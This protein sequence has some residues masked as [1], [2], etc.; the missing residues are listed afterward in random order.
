M[1]PVSAPTRESRDTPRILIVDDQPSNIQVL[2]EALGEGYEI[3]FATT[4]RRALELT[5][6]GD[7]DMVLLDIV[8]PEMDGFEVCRRI[9]ANER[10]GDTLVVFVT[11]R[12]EVAD[13]ARGFSV[14][15]VDYITKPVSPAVV[16][17]RVRTH[18]ELKRARDLLERVATHTREELAHVSRVATMSELT[19][20]LSHELSQPLAAIRT[21]ARAAELFLARATPDLDEARSALREI[22]ADIERASEVIRHLRSQLKRGEIKRERLDVNSLVAATVEV[23]R[24]EAIAHQIAVT[25]RPMLGL[26]AVL[27]DPVQI[28][29]VLLNLG[30]NAFEAMAAIPPDHRRLAIATSARDGLVEIEVRDS[31]PG[32]APSLLETLFQPFVSTKN[33]G[34]GI[35]LA[36]SRRIVEAHGGR[37]A[38]ANLPDGGASFT[39]GLPIAEPNG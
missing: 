16:A 1:D 18:L 13:E 32:I 20:S 35:G 27:G 24:S 3:H 14:G 33:D 7:V 5:E 30:L 19:A 25:T 2:A 31:G 4:A 21:N 29:Q 37:I 9:K 12:G 39:V 15:G 38:R 6:S 34:L 26:P 11:A 23:L 22:S 28:Q 17:A 8:M 10:S 36:I